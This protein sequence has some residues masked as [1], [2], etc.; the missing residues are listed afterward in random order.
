MGFASLNPSYETKDGPQPP[1]N[2]STKAHRRERQFAI[3][4]LITSQKI[5]LRQWRRPVLDWHGHN[6]SPASRNGARRAVSSARNRASAC[7]M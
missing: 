2:S 3:F 4:L 1:E 7:A 6:Y 5:L